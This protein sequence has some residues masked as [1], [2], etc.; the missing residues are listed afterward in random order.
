MAKLDLE[1]GKQELGHWTIHYLPPTGGKYAGQAG[2][3]GPARPVR[4]AQRPASP[5]ADKISR[6]RSV[7]GTLTVRTL[8][9]AELLGDGESLSIPRPEVRSVEKRRTRGM[10]QVVVTLADGQE[11][12]FDNGLM[13]VDKLVAL[14][15]AI[16]NRPAV[17]AWTRPAGSFAQPAAACG[18]GSGMG[19]PSAR[20]YPT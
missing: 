8:V 2:G 18:A 1:P 5:S 4:A 3:H 7:A 12:V 11:F 10:K 20:R 15:A 14:G 13:S 6:P 19:R 16:G 9:G 17:P